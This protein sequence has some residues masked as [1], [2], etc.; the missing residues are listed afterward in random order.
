MIHR[1][2]LISGTIKTERRYVKSE[3]MSARVTDRSI[4]K[5]Q[6]IITYLETTRVLRR[7]EP[8]AVEIIYSGIGRR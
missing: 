2:F 7:Y 5:F 8:N 3:L 4:S 1:R 6:K